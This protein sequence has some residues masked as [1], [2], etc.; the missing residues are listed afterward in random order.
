MKHGKTLDEIN[1]E[2]HVNEII[3]RDEEN[4][5]EE[6]PALQMAEDLI[7]QLPPDHEGRNRW[8]TSYGN[9]HEAKALQQ[10]G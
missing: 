9:S 6:S 7:L 1:S 3:S 8:L 2:E 4:A 5:K 10:K